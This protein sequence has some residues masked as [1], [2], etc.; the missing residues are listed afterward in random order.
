[1]SASRSTFASSPPRTCQAPAIISSGTHDAPH[2]HE[3]RKRVSVP[4]EP[5]LVQTEQVDV[6]GGDL[7]YSQPL[8]HWK[9]MRGFATNSAALDCLTECRLS[10][11]EGFA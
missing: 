10:K 8:S 9:K 11:M 4:A 1:M 5:G 6:G 3:R 7:T 2:R